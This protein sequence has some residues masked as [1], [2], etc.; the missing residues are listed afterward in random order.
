MDTV[1]LCLVF[2][3]ITVSELRCTWKNNNAKLRF[4]AKFAIYRNIT[5]KLNKRSMEIKDPLS[6]E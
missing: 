1:C 5:T 4:R 2:K 3:Q 6:I